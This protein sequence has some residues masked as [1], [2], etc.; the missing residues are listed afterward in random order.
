MANGPDWLHES[1]ELALAMDV[2]QGVKSGKSGQHAN[3]HA[4]LRDTLFQRLCWQCVEDARAEGFKGD[5]AI[6]RAVEILAEQ[7]SGHAEFETLKKYHKRV[8]AALKKP[9]GR[10]KYFV[11]ARDIAQSTRVFNEFSFHCKLLDE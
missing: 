3:S 8:N 4:K 7:E 11:P 10:A 2:S 1:I 9:E 6:A 5:E